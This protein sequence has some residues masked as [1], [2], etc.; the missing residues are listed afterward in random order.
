[1]LAKVGGA[2][3]S[4]GSQV[5]DAT[6][7]PLGADL[8]TLVG[9]LGNTVTKAGGWS[10]RTARMARCRSRTDH[11]PRR[12]DERGRRRW[13]R[14]PQQPVRPA[15]K[16]A[17]ES[18]A[19]Q[20]PGRPL[21]TLLGGTPLAGLSSTLGGTPLGSLTSSGLSGSPLSSLTSALGGSGS[22]SNPL[23]TLTGALSGVTSGGLGG[24]SGGQRPGARAG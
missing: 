18:R 2:L 4:A 19:R 10:I 16:L 15:A 6:Q 21:S 3:S 23:S 1:M 12:R 14:P 11:E 22:A 24:G 9:S 5:G 7:N 17:C 8:G 20:H 13:A